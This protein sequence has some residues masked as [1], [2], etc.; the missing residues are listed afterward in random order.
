MILKRMK[1]ISVPLFCLYLS[2]LSSNSEACNVPVFRYA[3]E[4][5][6]ADIYEI[7]V[8][9]RGPF[10]AEDKHHIE[11]LEE[12]SSKNIQKANYSIQTFDLAEQTSGQLFDLWKTLDKQTLPHIV[13]CYPRFS[14][15]PR[16][17]WS[18]P[19]TDKSVRKVIDSPARQEIAR[20]VLEGETAVW[21]FLES[22]EQKSDA[23]AARLLQSQLIKLVSR[24]NPRQKV[25][26]T[27]GELMQDDGNRPELPIAFSMIRI[28]RADPAEVLLI[29]IL[30]N[31]EADLHEYRSYPMA[32]P[33]FGRGRVLYA[34]VGGGINERNIQEAC[35]FLT[36]P[37][38]CEIKALN[39]GTDLLINA[40][41]ATLLSGTFAQNGGLPQLSGLSN[42]IP[43]KDTHQVLSST[44]KRDSTGTS[45]NL[46]EQ[47]GVELLSAIP[48]KSSL[49]SANPQAGTDDSLSQT[50]DRPAENSSNDTFDRDIS[51]SL[52][53][54][55]MLWIVMLGISV[56]VMISIIVMRKAK[57][58]NV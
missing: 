20:R 18:E 9:H 24:L 41:W 8:F 42:F 11:L 35:D 12:F 14:N 32:F 27:V 3:L 16:A 54:R 52:L 34:L 57:R 22:G 17:I 6:P 13:V 43:E 15:V 25:P 38:S 26:N 30:M 10:S 46:S 33:I 2:I 47:D 51:T 4:R 39:Q 53:A 19:L 50:S 40:D 48:E 37:C 55:N 56:V 1:I 58:N 36:G 45:P 28:S 5:W 23:A 29:A 49:E 44:T 7:I 21:V 31:S